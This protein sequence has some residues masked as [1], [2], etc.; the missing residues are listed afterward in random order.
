MI[1]SLSLCPSPKLLEAYLTENSLIDAIVVVDIL[2]A[3]A[4][5]LQ[6]LSLGAKS[7]IPVETFEEL[8]Y[9][10]DKTDYITAGERGGRKLPFAQFGNDPTEFT[11]EQVRD[12][13]V[14]LTTTNGTQTLRTAQKVG[15]LIPIYVGAVGNIK[16]LSSFLESRYQHILVAASGWKGRY[17]FEDSLFVAL[18]SRAFTSSITHF[19][20]ATSMALD[21]FSFYGDNW[22]DAISKSEHY[23]RLLRLISKEKIDYCLQE[24]IFSL[25]PRFIGDEIL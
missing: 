10:R 25:V 21:A 17:S 18:L 20:D 6:L 4:T 15:P 8:Q 5:I 14:V 12:K 16:A 22:R 24:D 3:T 13:R 19:D 23:Q 2:R 7:V 9:Y 11:K 1:K